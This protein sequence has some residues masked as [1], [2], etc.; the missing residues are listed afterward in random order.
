MGEYFNIPESEMRKILE[1]A[2]EK[3]NR[4]KED[5]GKEEQEKAEREEKRSGE[6]PGDTMRRIEKGETY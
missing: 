5:S 1:A 4:D 2:A 6:S 3:Q